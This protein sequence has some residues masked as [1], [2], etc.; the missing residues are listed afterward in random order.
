MRKLLFLSL[1]FSLTVAA[2]N[3]YRERIS[4]NG[5]WQL[6]LDSARAV[7][8]LDKEYI[9]TEKPFPDSIEL[10]GTVFLQDKET[11]YTGRAWYKREVNIPQSW[12]DKDVILHLGHTRLSTVFI[13][14]DLRSGDETLMLPQELNLQKVLKPG[15]H[16]LTVRIDN[17]NIGDFNGF[18]GDIYLEAADP[19]RFSEVQILPISSE[20]RLDFRIFVQGKITE[21]QHL[22]A[23]VKKN[24]VPTP[25]VKDLWIE[26]DKWDWYDSNAIAFSI[27]LD[28]APLWEPN[29]Q[30]ATLDV[31]VEIVG[32]DL[33]TTTS[34]F[35]NENLPSFAPKDIDDLESPFLAYTNDYDWNGFFIQRQIQ[36]TKVVIFRGECPSEEVFRLADTN[37]IMFCPTLPDLNDVNNPEW[38]V[39]RFL[40][41]ERHALITRYGHHP[42][43]D[44]SRLFPSGQ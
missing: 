38:D 4:L 9:G 2:Q 41:D 22:I 24:F 14:G 35:R 16:W 37:N 26:P 25:I 39:K 31:S 32:H 6:L 7:G 1:L 10:P 11:F 40:D 34:G 33:F 29:G 28:E 36:G 21:K 5:K 43:F 13:D 20:K 12:E 27:D 3:P 18:I 19:V 44:S 15:K 42:S 23:T 8:D 17:S 30:L